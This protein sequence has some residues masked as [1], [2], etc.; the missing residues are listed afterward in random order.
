MSSVLGI[1][2][3]GRG[4]VVA[5]MVL[6]G[7]LLYPDQASYLEKSLQVKDSKEC[8][9]SKRASLDRAIRRACSWETRTITAPAIDSLRRRGRSLNEIECHL[10]LKIIREF[11]AVRRFKVDTVVL[12]GASLFKSI[13]P[14]LLELYPDTRFVITDKADKIYTA[15]SAASIIA[16]VERDKIV[17][18]IMGDVPGSGYPNEHTK[19]WIERNPAYAR[20]HVRM[21]WDWE[22]L[23][24][25]RKP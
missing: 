14:K 21:T 23:E 4:C 16:K 18:S 13:F 8:T 10:A 24:V 5:D 20:A 15:A 7:V 6:A 17:R 19:E 11:L 9:P 1:D 12:D 3:A 25:L 22:G 2:E